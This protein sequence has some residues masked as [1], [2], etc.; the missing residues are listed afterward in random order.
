MY[1][2]FKMELNILIQYLLILIFEYQ[3]MIN[4]YPK[5]N[6]TMY[7]TRLLDTGIN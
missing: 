7:K 5:K 4:S 3:M 2:F 1:M 6:Y